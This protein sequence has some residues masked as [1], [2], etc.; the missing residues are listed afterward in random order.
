MR[1]TNQGNGRI[2]IVKDAGKAKMPMTVE[3]EKQARTRQY[4]T[5]ITTEQS[6]L[7][8]LLASGRIDVVVIDVGRE[9]SNTLATLR[10]LEGFPAIPIF[11]FNSFMLPRIEDKTREYG[12]IHYFE[13]NS[14]LEKFISSV[15]DAVRQKRQGQVQGISLAGFLQLMKNE[16]W[17]G[18]V[19][20]MSAG[21][22]GVLFLRDG[23][24][25]SAVA[26]GLAGQDA[27][28]KMAA[29]EKITVETSS[30]QS[31]TT[32]GAAETS[33]AALSLGNV[34]PA[35]PG[36][37]TGRTESGNIER[38]H[39][40]LQNRKIAL[41]LKNLNQ[42]LEEIRTMLS[43]SL[44]RTDIFLT[45]SGRSLAGWNSHPLACSSFAAITK[46]LKNSLQISRFPRLGSYYML[47]LN[48]DQ[49]LF[50]AVTEELQWG[51]LLTGAKKQLG[52]LLNIVLPKA[53]KAL[54]E[55][56]AVETTA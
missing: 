34:R 47:D 9:V 27:W 36:A 40:V 28:G 24:L 10:I 4:D 42:V 56:L 16:K 48:D 50:I 52:L 14:E 51:F 7:R 32:P 23:R 2:L 21:D 38:L 43:A 26:G 22:Q 39:L 8:Q 30:Q 6:K 20:V 1:N 55:S 49:V 5:M 12:H 15:M 33:A 45:D 13:N 17:N 35:K 46:S 54:E 31:P 19:K 25:V 44:L 18:Q 11:I 41:N 53:L 3:L 37:K 29:W